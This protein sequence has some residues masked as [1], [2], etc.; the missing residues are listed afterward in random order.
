MRGGG[1]DGN[2]RLTAATGAALVVLLAAFGITIL[3]VQSLIWW[4]FLLGMLLIPPV[5]LKLASTGWRFIR[6]YRGTPEYVRRGPPL[7]PLRLMAPLLVAATLTVFGTGI[8]LLVVGPTGGLLVGLHK[9]SF[10]VWFVVTAIHVLAHLR[11]L[12]GLVAA[13]WQRRPVPSERRVPGS[14]WRLWLLAVT[15]V[16]GAVLAAATVRYA[17]PWVH[18]FGANDGSAVSTH[19]AVTSRPYDLRIVGR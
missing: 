1:V 9:A 15:L 19:V 11:P 13:D 6:Y 7:L 18:W 14:S 12:P 5:L 16:A 17:K 2:E 10:I 3:S 4:H 8:A